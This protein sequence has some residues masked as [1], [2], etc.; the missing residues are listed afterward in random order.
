[1]TPK[2]VLSL[3]VAAIVSVGAAAAAW[4][5]SRPD[6]KVAG[7]GGE[8]LPELIDKVNTIAGIEVRHQGRSM[9]LKRE[10]GSWRVLPSG[11]AVKPRK[12]QETLVGLIRLNKLE[13]RTSKADKYAILQV[14]D[15][16]GAASKSRH[17]L[18]RDEA[19]KEVGSVLLGKAATGYT[20][21]AEAAQYVRL[22][23]EAQSWL[24]KGS[25]SAGAEYKD[26][27]DTTVVQINTGEVK[28]VTIT[29]ADGEMLELLKTGKTAQGHDQFTVQGLPEGIKVKDDLTVRYAATDLANVE[30]V[31]VRKAKPGGEV[32]ARAM[33]ETD[34]GLKV[35]YE[36]TREGEENWLSV[37]LLAAGEDAEGAEKL[38]ATVEGWDF[39]IAD[40]K[41]KQ[42][43]KRLSDVLDMQQ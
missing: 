36:M 33:L 28:S 24:V 21:G 19:G 35:A 2:L 26:W 18:L 5:A 6:T 15:A 41:A 32:V 1:M 31:G 3:G 43:R 39:A 37:S 23:G 14:E 40:Y 38:K 9:R 20:S 42:F 16:G 27:V 7:A 17:V 22:G 4:Q 12:L 30:F 8:L 10:D 11:Y 25:V 29:Q 13:P 34:K